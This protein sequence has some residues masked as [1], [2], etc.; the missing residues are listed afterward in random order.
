MKIIIKVTVSGSIV[1]KLWLQVAFF[2]DNCPLFCSGAVSG[3]VSWVQHWN[4]ELMCFR[5][6]H[7]YKPKFQQAQVRL[8]QNRTDLAQVKTEAVK[9]S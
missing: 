7:N 1:F 4:A 3:T 5:S 2:F 6:H 9:Q 8:N